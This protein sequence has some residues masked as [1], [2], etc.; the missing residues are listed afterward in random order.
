MFIFLVAG[1]LVFNSLTLQSNQANNSRAAG[2]TSKPSTT[3]LLRSPGCYA[4]TYQMCLYPSLQNNTALSFNLRGNAATLFESVK[5]VVTDDSKI[6][7]A[8]YYKDGSTQRNGVIA[9]LNGAEIKK[10][11]SFSYDLGEISDHPALSSVM[12]STSTKYILF[13]VSKETDPNATQQQDIACESKES[14]DVACESLH[15]ITTD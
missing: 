4:E 8:V 5:T 6:G 10:M 3:T 7:I 13:Y 14:A 2:Q 15:K 1:Y 12:H 11:R 9:T